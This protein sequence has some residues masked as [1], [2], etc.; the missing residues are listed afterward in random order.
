M[1]SKNAGYKA[2]TDI[3]SV[4]F[5]LTAIITGIQ[6]HQEVWHLH[7]Y[8]N[9]FLWSLHEIVGL[10]LFAGIILHCI[11]HSFWFKKY[12]KIQ[13]NR[14]IVTTL[15]LLLGVIVLISGVILMCG[16]HSEVLSH[17]HFAGAILFTVVAIGH[18]AKRFSIFKSIIKQNSLH[19]KEI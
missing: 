5:L 15:L 8:D 1:K 12:S 17:I 4:F 14:K 6:L 10:A 3:L 13:P 16:S 19:D 2:L 11:Q 7:V 9:T 18:V